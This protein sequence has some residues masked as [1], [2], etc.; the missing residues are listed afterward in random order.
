M[1]ALSLLLWLLDCVLFVC[2]C[3][4]VG[5]FVL[6]ALVVNCGYLVGNRLFYGLLFDLLFVVGYVVCLLVCLLCWLC[7]L[8]EFSMVGYGLF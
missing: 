1:I 8:L 6:F 3:L 7:F 5:C 4:G 2:V